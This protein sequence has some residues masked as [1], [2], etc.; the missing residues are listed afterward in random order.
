MQNKKAT[1][2][3]K[4]NDDKCFQYTVTVALSY[5]SI[6]NDP[7]RISKIE[8]FIDQYNCKKI[9]FPSNKKHC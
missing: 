4:N 7:E 6:K 3:L 8:A 9:I 2:N 1:I 5:Q